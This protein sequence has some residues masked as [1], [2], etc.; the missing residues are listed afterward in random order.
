MLY[1]TH[2]R[3]LAATIQILIHYVCFAFFVYSFIRGLLSFLDRCLVLDFSC[4][5]FFLNVSLFS[6]SVMFVR[7]FRSFNLFLFNFNFI[8]HLVRAS[9]IEFNPILKNLE[10][11]H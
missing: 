6:F 2:Q 11:K 8:R 3:Q 9:R 10:A 5:T 4:N 1:I 7:F